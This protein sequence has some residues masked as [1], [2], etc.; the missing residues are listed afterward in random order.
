MQK[1]LRL[2]T[3]LTVLLGL[4]CLPG[5]ADD[6]TN[7][8]SASSNPTGTT[9]GMTTSTTGTAPVCGDGTPDPGEQCD[10]GNTTSGD[11]CAS[12]CTDEP[13]ACGD[14]TV[15]PGEGCDDGN[16]TSGDGCSA[17]CA[18]EALCG[19]TQ[20]DPGEECDDGNMTP[21]DGCENDC[22]NTAAMEV[23]CEII[24]PL[25]SGTCAV[26][27]GDDTKL[28]IG[29][30]LTPDTI[31]R[32]GQVAVDAAGVISCVGCDCPSPG[33]TTITCPMGVIS[34]ALINTHD[35][36]TF[37]QNNPYNDTGER[38]EHRHDWRSGL[39]GHTEIN[40]PGSAST[41]EV[42]WGEL[43][44]LMGGAT[45]T[46]GSGA[47]TGILR[48]LD[49]PQQEG[50]GQP[51]VNF[52][53]FPLGDS[54]STQLASGC[55]YPNI[56]QASS[57]AG[58]DAFLPHVSEGIDAF[59]RNEF[60][61]MSTSGNGAQDLVTPQSAF[62]HSIGLHASD[63]A[64]MAAEGTA[65]IWSPRSNI[66][67]YGDTAVVT[68]A[69]RL[70]VLVAL[71]TDWVATGSMNMLRELRCAD[72]LN[73]TH[74][75]G[76]FTDR[77]L[78]LMATANAAVATATDDVIGILA[79]GKV[80]DI[81]IF[82]G[83]VNA[84]HRAIIDAEPEDVALVVRGGKVL[85]GDETI[86]ATIPGTGACDALDVC[87]TSKQ[88]C[89]STDIG[90]TLS[91][92]E[93]SVGAIY[94]AFFCGGTPNNEPSCVPTRPVSVN[95]STVYTGAVSAAD[96]DGDGIDDTADN[97]VTIFNPIRPVDDSA[98]GDFDA[99]G[100]GDACDVC[101]LD[102]NTTTCTSFDP[103]DLDG[104]GVVNAADNCPNLSN[105]LQ[106][107]GDTDGRGD[108]CDACPTQPNPA[109]AACA[110]SIYD[111]KNGTLAEG[112]AVAL[113]NKLVTARNTRGFFLQATPSDMDY[114]GPD[115]S[116]V[117]VFDQ[118]NTVTVGDRVSI[119]TATI[120]DFF[121]QIQLSMP[122]TVINTSL[123]EAAP[124]PV[125]APA[126][127]LAT[128]GSSAAALE[129][130]LVQVQGV[131][132]TSVTPPV[133]PG[134]M[135]PINELVVDGVLRVN[136][137]LYLASPFPTVGQNFTSITGILDFKNGDSKIEPRGPSDYV[138]GSATLVDFG[139]S[140][141]FARV[142]Q[143]GAPT[144]PT[145]LSVTLSN[146]VA[147]DTFVMVMSSDPA[148]LAVI[149]GGVTVPAGSTSAPVLVDGLAQ[150]A[151]VMLTATL[152]M[153]S[154]DA[155][156]RVIDA[157]EVPALVSLTPGA[158][159]V[160]PGGTAT[161]TVA[162]DIPAP[163]GGTSV[164]LALAPVAA[165]AIP[166]T[167]LVPADQLTATFDYVDAGTDPA[168]TITASLA[169]ATFDATVTVVA[170]MGGLVINEVD[171]DQVG[172]DMAEFI[173]I[174][175]GTGAPV[176]LAGLSLALV[177]GS[178]NAQYLS[179][180]LGPAGT[181]AAGQYLIVATAAVMPAPGA[182]VITFVPIA[183]GSVQNGAP[184]AIAL[185]DTN[186]MQLVDAL[187]YEGS[188]TAGM[189]TGLGVVSLVE[190]AA[191]ADATADSNTVAGSLC[192]LPNGNDTNNA[193]TDWNFTSMP[194]PGAA[195]VP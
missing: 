183:G 82:D 80:A 60:V 78:W 143:T 7:T 26:T 171:Y 174:Y 79:A 160:A 192:R 127:N 191:L 151:G 128:G 88:V 96:G 28:F 155:S 111:I 156:V 138:A 27:A 165:G 100:V 93:A 137:F 119:T 57:I 98:Q 19:N 117:F 35:H 84:D 49:R 134:D 32:G 66:T 99:D 106:E 124:A 167:V 113:N 14:G 31:Y 142:G 51:E 73:S 109:P 9:S 12:D 77:D 157:A 146:S 159:T 188:I 172:G 126:A 13:A 52:Q 45:S 132:V 185:V 11:G 10:D 182:L 189:V 56:I 81:S 148:S 112:T 34:P 67:L 75:A 105:P 145:P 125:V 149:G 90:K 120:L 194:T 175:N 94:P 65:V 163:A 169:T 68:E 22:S 177:N 139:P 97:C 123:G 158:T 44:F 153:V 178:N 144:I 147:T 89:L 39:N 95:G 150:S 181:L 152:D 46:V 195:N 21:G 20:L 85:Y 180:D 41:D 187:S 135:A 54:N 40:T 168:A 59:A 55:G 3:T 17:L 37:T 161:F 30:V 108:V 87:G 173:E 71:G 141:S 63:Y 107:D 69:A 16:T 193:A 48:N 190:G 15:D 38:Y 50:L 5:C 164:T 131:S 179:F 136:D 70:G 6:E 33:A 24:D 103:N 64:A 170:V 166:A 162:L 58:E 1:S 25:P 129:A 62:I 140:P 83:S 43:R 186:T 92:L 86:V 115:F 76:F 176:P 18:E 121:G 36:I 61:C 23:V 130:V 8:T 122:I 4:V 101:P 104:D 2:W 53:T 102:A 42:R 72:D 154:F 133:G 184:D 118:S 114:A 91:Q 74:Y 116:G 47:A 29:T 110:V